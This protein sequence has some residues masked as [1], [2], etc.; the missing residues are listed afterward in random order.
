MSFLTVTNVEVLNSNVDFLQ[1]EFRAV[2]LIVS[3]LSTVPCLLLAVRQC[4]PCIA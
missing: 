3:F 1:L 4:H 2:R